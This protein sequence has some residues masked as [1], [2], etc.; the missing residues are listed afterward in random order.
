MR[1][2]I[3]SR[4]NGPT[5]PLYRFVP[6]IEGALFWQEAEKEWVHRVCRAMSQEQITINPPF[7][8]GGTCCTDFRVES[9]P[10]GGFV[11]SCEAPI[12]V[13]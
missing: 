9:R 11:A 12:F 4:T 3:A 7:G 6:R 13:S 2:Y 5:R 10:Q 1:W 8:D